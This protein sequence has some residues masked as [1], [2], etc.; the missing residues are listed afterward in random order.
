MVSLLCVNDRTHSQLMDLMPEKCGLAGQTKDFEPTLTLIADYKA[1]N[2]EAGGG[3]QQG[4]YVPKAHVWENDFSP[5]Y[6]LLRA[7]HRRDFQ[8]AMDRYTT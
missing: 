1:P 2:F 3:M 8:S 4:M 5:I 7:V 6:T